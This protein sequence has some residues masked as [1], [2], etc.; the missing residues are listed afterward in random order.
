M[1]VGISS[2]VIVAYFFKYVWKSKQEI[3]FEK[4]AEKAIQLLFSHLSYVDSYKSTI[5]QYL[6]KQQNYDINNT[7]HLTLPEWD[8]KEVL[9]FR[10]LI[11]D[12][13]KNLSQLQKYSTYLTLEQYLATLQYSTS[14][15]SFIIPIRN[16]E[17]GI[18]I[19][20]KSLEFHI[21]HAKEI[22]ELFEK[23][24]PKYFKEN[25]EPEFK[26]MGGINL[27]KT[28]KTEPGDIIGPHH[29]LRN[30]LLYYDYAFSEIMK[31]IIEIKKMLKEPKEDN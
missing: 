13:V 25:W 10:E 1:I 7:S 29:N 11:L 5:F 18:S 20:K 31:E 4:N 8:Y 27:I 24:T 15:Y 30:E 14:I 6:E 3:I 23:S 2:T 16:E 21:Y 19:D 28:P 17:F 26:K 22:I 12:E 9:R